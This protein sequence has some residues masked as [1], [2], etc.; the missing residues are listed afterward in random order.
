MAVA[1]DII[2]KQGIYVTTIEDVTEKA[3]IG[4]GTFYQYFSGKDELLE[5][6]L[7]EGL[8][9]LMAQCREYSKKSSNVG[10]GLRMVVK[11]HV[12]FLMNEESFVLIFH[13]VRGLLQL[14][15]EISANLKEIY[16]D[17]LLQLASLLDQF[18]GTSPHSLQKS[19]EIAL[20]LASYSTGLINHYRLFHKKMNLS[21]D[22]E[23][24]EKRIIT[25]LQ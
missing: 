14:K 7:K 21:V 6:L 13:Q 17:Y 16:G 3:D 12:E 4:K 22:S 23:K 20:S 10:D 24:I 1:I 5:T 25:A 2:S 19:R 8:E 11:A 18:L 9:K 15:Q